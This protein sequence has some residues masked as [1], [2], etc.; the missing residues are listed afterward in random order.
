ML[1]PHHLYKCIHGFQVRASMRACQCVGRVWHVF[2]LE[3]VVVCM[4]GAKE[5]RRGEEDE[6]RMPI[7]HEGNG[8]HLERQ[9][10]RVTQWGALAAPIQSRLRGW[11][12]KAS[13]SARLWYCLHVSSSLGGSQ[14]GTE[15]EPTRAR[16]ARGNKR[17]RVG[18]EG[19]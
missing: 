7:K 3:H 13:T 10:A 19:A 6:S 5:S 8:V 9:F 4:P 15:R 1:L 2:V 18:C 11:Q 12:Q 17:D 14:K 16:R